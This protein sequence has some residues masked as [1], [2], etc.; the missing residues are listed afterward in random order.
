MF[1]LMLRPHVCFFHKHFHRQI[2]SVKILYNSQHS[3]VQYHRTSYVVA[4]KLKR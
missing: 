2:Y 3:I 1:I 4:E